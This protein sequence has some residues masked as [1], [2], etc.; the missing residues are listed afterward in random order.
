MKTRKTIAFLRC[1][2]WRLLLSIS[3]LSPLPSM[4]SIRPGTFMAIEILS[5]FYRWTFPIRISFSH[6]PMREATCPMIFRIV[7]LE[8]VDD[9]IAVCAR[10]ITPIVASV[11]NDALRRLCKISPVLIHSRNKWPKS[12]IEPTIWFHWWW[13]PDGIERRLISIERWTKPRSIIP[14]RSRHIKDTTNIWK[15]PFDVSSVDWTE[16]DYF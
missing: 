10:S 9:W 4:R 13:S 3:A 12:C 6:R 2:R 15:R 14:K 16:K 1:R 7:R 8:D 11:V 5:K